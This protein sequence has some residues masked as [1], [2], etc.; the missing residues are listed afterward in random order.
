M[1]LL[2]LPDELLCCIS[3]NLNLERDINAFAQANRHLYRLLNTYL[4][5]YNIR[6]SRSS[7]LLWAA[8]YG[9]EA[10]AQK[11]LGERADG[12][13][14]SGYY[15]IPLQ[16]AS[17]G[18]HE[19][20]VQLLLDKDADVNAQDGVHGNALQVASFGGQ[21]QIVSLLV[22]KGADVNAQGGYFGNALQAASHRGHEQI[23]GLL[24][25]NGAHRPV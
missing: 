4:Y 10:T 21:E 7:A 14:T 17:Y 20:I 11:L 15:R 19:Q 24:Q 2:R 6:Y 5:R 18:G 25:D 16:A 1:P 13:A 3:E 8:Q 9:Q 23:V 12:Q 22:D